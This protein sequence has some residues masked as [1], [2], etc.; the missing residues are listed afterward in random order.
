MGN[1]KLL[2]VKNLKTYF[3][4]ED[5]I[6]KAVDG[7]SFNVN[8]GETLGIVGESGCGKSVTAL[9]I[10][11][12]LPGSRGEIVDG[13]IL[14]HKSD[15][16]II[17]ITKMNPRGKEIRKI[18]GNEIGMI[19]Q[20]PMKSLNPVHTIGFQIREAVQLHQGLDK[21]QA[22]E[23][24]IEMLKLVGISSPEERV[25]QY[26]YELSGGM[27]Q[28]AMIAIGLSCNP[29]I[30][31]VDEP[32]TAL[33]VTIEA[34]ILELMV[35]LQ[36]K[37]GMSITLITH[38][39]DVIGEMAD[40]VVVMYLGGVVESGTIDH[41]LDNPKHPYTVGL[42]KSIPEIGR[43]ERLTPIKGSVPNMKHLP[44][45]CYFSPRC[46]ECF[47]KCLDRPEMIMVEENHYV[48]CW[49]YTGIKT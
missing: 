25:D 41:I 40:R 39:L 43:K 22:R 24:A 2:E 46:Q 15:S 38:D 36:K 42:I 12:L 28:R 4:H 13:N 7:V 11:Y 35:E 8:R 17:D 34:Q 31:I 18:R 1:E 6:V 9:S 26:P 32:T 33:D 5:V 29:K 3:D 47:D 49:L 44:D 16:E 10:M 14:Y 48:S 21:K 19:F 27:R 45:G 23:R 30:L 37:F 20:E